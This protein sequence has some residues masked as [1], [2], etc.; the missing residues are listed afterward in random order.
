[1]KTVVHYRAG[2]YLP[3][4]ENWI[5]GQIRG[6]KRYRPIVYCHGKQ[7]LGTYPVS[8]VRAL[9]SKPGLRHPW[10]FFNMALNKVI[11]FNPL[12]AFFLI[13]DRPDIVHAHFGK[14]GYYFLNHKKI[15]KFPLVTT[16]YGHDLSSLPNRKPE[17]KRRYKR[18]FLKGDCFL[19]EGSH[20]KKCLV[21]L[22]CPE[23]KVF[24][25]H[26]G[27]DLDSVR[28]VERNPGEDGEIRVL[29]SASF[30]HKKG[31]PIG[32]EAFSRVA[33][34]H[35]DLNMRLTIVG[36]SAGNPGEEEEKRKILSRI[37]EYGLSGRV[38]LL[39]YQPHSLYLKELYEHHIFLSPSITAPDG[40]TEGGVPVTILEASAS[41]MPVL[42]TLHCD[43]PEAVID[44][45][46]GCLV[47]ERDVDA[48]SERLFHLAS[49]PGIWRNMGLNG[50]RHIE[51]D[52]D[53]KKQIRKLE[54]IYSMFG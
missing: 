21:E 32:I 12:F 10:T 19:V 3:T 22:G 11:K 31:I 20:M 53:V 5:Y 9:G 49:N 42:S 27:I 33:L 50:R 16:F 38:N 35:P 17:W 39:G 23:N 18:L 37:E 4:T 54:D 44:K 15:F 36:D 52:Y 46:S 28:F 34:N 13:K 43:I 6:L 48:L 45:E 8:T 51:S 2:T 7:N 1:M 41:G 29:M 14:S 25:Q 24:V 26:L 30:R 40:D 47:R